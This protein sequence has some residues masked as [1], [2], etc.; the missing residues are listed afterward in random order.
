MAGDYKLFTTMNVRELQYVSVGAS[1]QTYGSIGYYPTNNTRV[2]F[3]YVNLPNQGSNAGYACV[4]G[5]ENAMNLRFIG[6][7]KVLFY[8]YSE[9]NSYDSYE[10]ISLEIGRHYIKIDGVTVATGNYGGSFTSSVPFVIGCMNTTGW[11][12]LTDTATKF[13]KFKIYE[14]ETLAAEY[15]PALN[16]SNVAGFYCITTDTFY[17]S[18]GA[19]DWV[20]G[21]LMSSINASASKTRLAASGETIN[22]TV[23]TE[24]AWTVSGNTFLTLSSTGDTSGDT[25]T[26]TAPN[27]TGTTNREETLWFIDSVTGDEAELTIVQKKAQTGQPMFLGDDEITDIY[28]GDN[29]ISEAYLGDVLVYS[30]GPFQ[31]MR[32]T[33]KT[34]KFNASALTADITVKSSEA[35]TATTPAWVT[36]SPSTGD[37][38][39]TTITL[40]ATAQ[41][42]DTEAV[43]TITSASYSASVET[44]YSFTRY[45]H[46]SDIGYGTFSPLETGIVPDI[47]TYGILDGRYVGISGGTAN[48][49]VGYFTRDSNDWR[50][51]KIT[52]EPGSTNNNTYMD[53]GNQRVNNA[54]IWYPTETEDFEFEFGNLYIKNRKTDVTATGNAYNGSLTGESIKINLGSMW[55]HRLRLYTQ[56]NLVFDGE[57]ACVNGQYGLKD[58]VSGNFFG[59][60]DFTIVGEV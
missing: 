51:F 14:G 57:A 2:V 37:T 5:A 13:G 56:N 59:S 30:S 34:V 23:S 29:A 55:I 49:L 22:I 28:L 36:A 33:P 53:V 12:P 11:D 3:D 15:I 60:T 1:S 46:S 16:S 47:T 48:Y 32:V 50:F 18:Q 9:A 39:E 21:P 41:T 58:S 10:D 7:R 4:I 52:P 43:T 27:Y 42:A 24:N 20:A 8:G 6:N 45:I 19:S 38:G 25:I 44:N 40:T 31:G 26:A 17:P 54:Q 35:W